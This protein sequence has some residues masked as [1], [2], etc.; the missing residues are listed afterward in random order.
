MSRFQ[1]RDY[2][3][4]AISAVVSAR[5][6]GVRRMV[7]VLPTGAGKTVIFSELVRLAKRP[8][9][10][11]AHRGE[12]VSQAADK[13]RRA[14]GDDP[15]AARVAIEQADRHAPDDAHVVVASIRSLHDRR[16]ARLLAVRA[17][18]L[19]VYDECHHAR[20]VRNSGENVCGPQ[21]LSQRDETL[22]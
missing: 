10:V 11:L 12:L 2:Q 13:I 1:L 15:R 17:F 9:L 7:V 8:V 5:K 18:G 21:I 14:L 19:V 20:D 22:E 16:L 6:S 3:R 4:E